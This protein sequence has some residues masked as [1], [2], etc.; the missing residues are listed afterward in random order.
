MI[1][2]DYS[3]GHQFVG[4]SS[5]IDILRNDL[6]DT[7]IKVV[8]LDGG[9]GV[10]KT[11]LAN[12][13]LEM[14]SAGAL[15]GRFEKQVS[16]SAYQE[17]W[18]RVLSQLAEKLIGS[19]TVLK[20]TRNEI[21]DRILN[22]C[23]EVKVFLVLDNI[24]SYHHDDAIEFIEAWLKL[25]QNSVLLITTREHININ[26]DYVR[27]IRLT[28]LTDKYPQL[29]LLG[30][31]LRQRFGEPLI[32]LV[33][34]LD[35]VPLNL[36][37]LRWLD[38]KTEDDLR[39]HVFRLIQGTLDK[40]SVLEEVLESASHSPTAFMAL[41]VVR[42]LEFNESLLASF[43]DRMGGGNSEAYI[44]FRERLVSSGLLIPVPSQEIKTSKYRINEDIH[45]QLY[46]ALSSRIGGEGRVP[47]VHFFASEYYRRIFESSLTPALDALGEFVHHSFSSNDY[48]RAY[49]YLFES[50]TLPSLHRAGMAIQ[51]KGILDAFLTSEA[52][53]KVLEQCKILIEMAHVCNDLSEF[54]QCLGVMSRAEALLKEIADADT[55][56]IE[57][58]KRIWYYSAV[59]YSN[60]GHSEDCLKS[61]FKIVSTTSHPADTLACVSLAY[62]AHDLKYRDID[63]SLRYGETA[64]GISRRIGIPLLIAKCLGSVAESYIF[65]HNLS[66]ADLYF[67]EA[68]G[69]C[70][71]RTS[72][73]ADRRELGRVLKNWGVVALIQKRWDK[74]KQRL[75]NARV[76]STSVGDRRRAATADLYLAVLHYHL[77]EYQV[78]DELM[79]SAIKA[80]HSLSD[81]RY[82][83]PEVMTFARWK[84]T[85]YSGQ[86]A[87]L[88]TCNNFE[89]IRNIIVQVS[90]TER[91]QIYATFWRDFFWPTLF[92]PLN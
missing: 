9:L 67:Q 3:K 83:V 48:G 16:Q 22:F 4:R 42:Q 61:Y 66:K 49:E 37:Y 84:N 63:K 12:R 88:L 68:E 41:G 58:L 8:C 33:R 47:T 10:G 7:K 14:S 1:T 69:L 75:V 72:G 86:L 40:S 26:R 59:A 45:K 36:L 57:L 27:H 46:R 51:L 52:H 20:A 24:E 92:E 29:E 11:A 90:S 23:N 38:P 34:G 30:D 13:L 35:G 78:A 19:S 32:E 73:T 53:F 65:S 81:G 44:N 77:E 5:E 17:A 21:E 18:D 43:W 15:A 71:D 76:I 28:G 74:A 50:N 79:I 87:E 54:S 82:L 31:V 62:I 70:Q 39:T 60:T 85:N 91:Y 55:R 25:V 6:S 89:A 56:K 80:S 2:F 64:L